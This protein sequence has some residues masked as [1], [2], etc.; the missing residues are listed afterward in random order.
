MAI[1]RC[2]REDSSQALGSGLWAPVGSDYSEESQT[3]VS[4]VAKLERF[5]NR[6]DRA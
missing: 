2:H 6:K 4:F 3:L 1:S 5:P